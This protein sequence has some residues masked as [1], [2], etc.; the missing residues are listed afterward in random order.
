MNIIIYGID[1]DTLLSIADIPYEYEEVE[2]DEIVK[3]VIC[4]NC[5]YCKEMGAGYDCP[6]GWGYLYCIH[7][8]SVVFEDQY[9]AWGEEK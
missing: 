7:H 3:G 4:R 5:R 6:S 9:C 8:K 2:D 1:E